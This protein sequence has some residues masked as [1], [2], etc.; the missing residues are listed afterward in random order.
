[1]KLIKKTILKESLTRY[2][3]TIKRTANFVANGIIVHNCNFRAAVRP[4]DKLF[5]IG[6]H[7]K[8]KKLGSG[9]TFEE[10]A[11]KYDLEAK[12]GK[13]PGLMLCGEIY[14]QVQDLKYNA[15]PGEYFLAAFDL[16]DCNKG[17]YLDFEDFIKITTELAIP[18]APVLYKGPWNE[19]LWAL[20]EG[21]AD[22]NGATHTREGIVIKTAV[23]T[24]HRHLGRCVV[25]LVGQGF[26]LRP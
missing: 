1:M 12:L 19:W 5:F 9:T 6:S 21:P 7:H 23:E 14:G 10:V 2:D 11:I 20:A 3:L 17:K 25:K 22:I 4:E 13:Y 26:L 16:F 8:I 15:G 24:W 18:T